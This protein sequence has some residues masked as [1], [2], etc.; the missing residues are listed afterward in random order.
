MEAKME[1]SPADART[2]IGAQVGL[3]WLNLAGLLAILAFLWNLS[4][5]IS[6]LGERM[7]RIEGLIEGSRGALVAKTKPE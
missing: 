3:G 6:E 1:S 2:P 4:S 7:A 5:D